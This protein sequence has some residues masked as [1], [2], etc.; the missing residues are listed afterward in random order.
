MALLICAIGG[1]RENRKEPTSP[2]AGNAYGII[3]TVLLMMF[4]AAVFFGPRAPLLLAGR[5]LRITGGALC[6]VGLLLLFAGVR[7]LGAAIQVNPSPKAGAKLVT[8]GIYRWFRHP[9]YTAIVFVVIGLFLRTPTVAVAGAT[10]IVILYIAVKIRFEERMLLASYPDY[11]EYKHQAWGL[12]P[13]P[14]G[15]SKHS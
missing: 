3:Q 13:W 12:V 10:A 8:T 4:A 6:A 5:A 7:H 2:K 11:A 14:R 9:I 15:R 1:E